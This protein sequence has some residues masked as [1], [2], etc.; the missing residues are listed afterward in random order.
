MPCV[1]MPRFREHNAILR[2]SFGGFIYRQR[3]EVITA[4]VCN[5]AALV[6]E[7]E[8]RSST[9]TYFSRLD[10]SPHRFH[11]RFHRIAG[12]GFTEQFLY[13]LFHFSVTAFPGMVEAEDAV[14]VEQK[15]RRPVMV[16]V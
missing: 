5:D 15:F 2:L 6:S 1:R 4:N 3:I 16:A 12:R 11:C 10:L 14:P 8:F 13:H 7:I 9:V